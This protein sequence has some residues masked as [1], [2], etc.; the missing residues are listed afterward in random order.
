MQK[1]VRN[2]LN[3]I[4]PRH[5]IQSVEKLTPR[6]FKFKTGQVVKLLS[7]S[8]NGLSKQDLLVFF[9][10]NFD[11]A[12]LLRRESLKMSVEKIIQRARLSFKDHHLSIVFDKKT[13]RYLLKPIG[14]RGQAAE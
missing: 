7:N 10:E 11:S 6:K 8:H 12:S 3:V 4:N 14:S 9:C 2:S 1:M 5:L 13:K